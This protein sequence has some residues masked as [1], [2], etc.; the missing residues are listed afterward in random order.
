MTTD[1]V[2]NAI[3]LAFCADCRERM[4]R[5]TGIVQERMPLDGAQLDRLHQEFDTLFGGARAV[6]MPELEHYFRQMARYARYLRNRQAT[7]QMIDQQSWQTLLAG[8]EAV[9]YCEDALLGC[10]DRCSSDRIQLARRMEDIINNGGGAMKILIVDDSKTSRL[11]FKAYMP[12]DEPHQVFEAAS[13]ADALELLREMQPDLVVLDYNMPEYNGVEM[14]QAI[15]QAGFKPKMALLTANTQ[16]MVV[17][18]AKAAGFM[19]VLEKPVNTEK[20]ATLL[21]QV[22]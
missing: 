13:L 14:A 17:D 10:I 11:L 16:K 1:R 19:Q 12:K 6:H 5:V 20:I 18:A 7:E 22:T 3:T 15:S 2:H 8:I 9:P 4:S 21:K